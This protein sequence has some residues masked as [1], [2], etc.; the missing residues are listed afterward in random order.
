MK[1]FR[2]IAPVF[3]DNFKKFADDTR[4]ASLKAVGKDGQRGIVAGLYQMAN[5]CD[6]AKGKQANTDRI[7]RAM[8]ALAKRGVKLLACPEMCLQGY[9]TWVDGDADKA[10][11]AG[12][13]LADDPATSKQ[14]AQLRKAARAAG[15]VLAFGFSEKAAGGKKVFNSIGVIDADG[16]WLGSHRKNPLFPWDYETKVFDEPPKAQRVSVFK[17]KVAAIGVTNCFDGSFPETIRA[18]RLAGAEMLVWCNAAVGDRKMGN[19]D[20][21]PTA[22]SYATAHNMPIVCCNG[23]AENLS[24]TSSI[25]AAGGVPMVI[26][27]P[28]EEGFGLAT[29]NLAAAANWEIYRTRLVLKPK[30]QTPRP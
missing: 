20:R 9:F 25:C 23:A 24:G 5:H 6:G 12:R 22:S 28:G 19:F 14:I 15:M 1:T 2:D 29:V 16:K 13:S 30:A 3:L 18:L 11:A 17:T 27:P 4:K 7:C 26:L 8:A 10:R 21:V